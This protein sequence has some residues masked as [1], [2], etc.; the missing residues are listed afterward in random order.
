MHPPV[1]FETRF[2]AHFG[3]IVVGPT[4]SGKSHFVFELIRHRAE[5]IDK[6]PQRI[7]YCFGEW[8]DAFSDLENEV[9]GLSFVKGIDEMVNN[10]GFFD[11]SKSTLL[12]IDDLAAEIAGNPKASKLFTQG[13][14]HRNVSVILILQNLYKQ[15]PAMRDIHL[16]NQYLV[17]FKNIRDINQ[18]KVLARQMGLDHLPMAYKKVTDEKYQPVVIDMKPDTPDYLRIRS[19]VLPGQMMRIYLP[20][21]GIKLPPCRK[22]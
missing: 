18:I 16:N 15:G 13:I 5:M 9:E 22:E 20:K 14:H 3:M 4:C 6:P 12:V 21:T 7:V 2:R 1:D 8:Q 19:H 11:A 17:M 10:D